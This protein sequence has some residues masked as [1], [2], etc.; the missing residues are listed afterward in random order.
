MSSTRTSGFFMHGDYAPAPFQTEVR[1]CG[2]T[3]KRNMSINT[4]V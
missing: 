1:V 2:F 4:I 3:Q